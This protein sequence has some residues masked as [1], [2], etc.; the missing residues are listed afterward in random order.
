MNFVQITSPPPPLPGRSQAV[1]PASADY[2]LLCPASQ[3]F[4]R[5]PDRDPNLTQIRFPIQVGSSLAICY[6]RRLVLP[7]LN[8]ATSTLVPEAD[9]RVTS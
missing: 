3:L 7:L 1:V 2:P 5:R 6:E 8:L 4:A 9:E